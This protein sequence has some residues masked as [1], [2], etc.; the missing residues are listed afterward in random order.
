MLRRR[1]YTLG[2]ICAVFSAF[3]ITVLIYTALLPDINL[4]IRKP[5]VY[6][7]K[8]L[9][10]FGYMV[11][12]LLLLQSFYHLF[13]IRRLRSFWTVIY[14]S[15]LVGGLTEVLQ[16]YFTNGTRR[17]ELGDFVAD[18]L[19]ALSVFV[20]FLLKTKEKSQFAKNPK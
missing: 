19:G 8:I 7:D 3:Y 2:S 4:G 10:F 6:F 14:I 12:S 17:A 20:L 5:I 16:H 18:V 1:S 9:H 13:R 15:A 11:L